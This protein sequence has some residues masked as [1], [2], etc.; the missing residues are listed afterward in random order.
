MIESWTLDDGTA[1]ASPAA[2][3]ALLR[4]RIADG[5]LETLLTSSRGRSLAVITNTERAMVMLLDDES[6]PGEHAV[7]LEA[8]GSSGGFVLAN[9]QNDEYPDKDTVPLTEALRI[10]SHILA[11]GAPPADAAWSIDR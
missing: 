8:A 2:V 7:T 5:Q 11:A 3:L 1:P 4:E 9:G 6:D 10:I